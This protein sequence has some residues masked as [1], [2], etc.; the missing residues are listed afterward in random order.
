MRCLDP[1]YVR[2]AYPAAAAALAHPDDIIR[3]VHFDG[4][5]YLLDE[6]HYG[7]SIAFWMPLNKLWAPHARRLS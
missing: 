6:A 2:A 7:Y 4:Y 5:L 3:I 1:D